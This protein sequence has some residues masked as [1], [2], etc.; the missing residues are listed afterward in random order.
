MTKIAILSYMHLSIIHW[1]CNRSVIRGLCFCAWLVVLFACGNKTDQN[2]VGKKTDLQEEKTPV[3]EASGVPSVEGMVWVPAGKFRMGAPGPGEYRR[4]YPA[5]EVSVDGFYMD[6]HE[7]TNAMYKA[8]VDATDYITIAERKVD[9]VEMEKQLPPGT[10]KPVDSLLQPGSL[11]FSPPIHRVNLNDYSN[12]WKW[13]LNTSWQHPEGK[14]SNIHSRM[15]HPVVH[16]AYEDALA[17]CE[18]AGKRL[19][20]EAEW[21]Y[22]AKGGLI[23]KRFVWGDE[24]PVENPKLANTWQGEFPLKNLGLDGFEGSAAVGSFKPNG[25]GLY[26]M[27]GNV[28]EWCSDLFD[29]NYYA[30]LLDKGI[31]YNPPGSGKSYDH[32]DPYTPK[33]INKGGSFLCH[34]SYCENYRPSAREGTSEDTGMSHLGFRCVKDYNNQ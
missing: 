25:Y 23:N 1:V 11:V 27:A 20:T 2:D 34:V 4:E 18:W 5:H 19:P 9:W 30:S 14:E 13:K 32:R 7:V 28:W 22:A 6:V 3:K 31:C 29:D 8:F 10:P 21:E 33:R 24:D 15:Q 12:W 16:I 26:D 17:Y